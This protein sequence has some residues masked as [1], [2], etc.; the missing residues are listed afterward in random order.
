MLKELTLFLS[1]EVVVVVLPGKV[2]VLPCKVVVLP[3]QVVVVTVVAEVL[4]SQAQ[5]YRV[6]Y[7]AE[8]YFVRGTLRRGKE[9]Q[10]VRL[11]NIYVFLM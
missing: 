11:S 5:V 9:Y 3:G 6:C 10:L 1:I 7:S 2:V 4:L 8:R